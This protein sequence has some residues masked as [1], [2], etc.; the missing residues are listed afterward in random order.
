MPQVGEGTD[1]E[2]SRRIGALDELR[3][4]LADER[5]LPKRERDSDIIQGLRN[6]IRA[7][8]RLQEAEGAADTAEAATR[9]FADLSPSE[10]AQITKG[11]NQ[12]NPYKQKKRERDLKDRLVAAANKE[13]RKVI[14]DEVKAKR[15]KK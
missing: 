1:V 15:P 2:R 10:K 13:E 4:A 7:A 8:E 12:I 5:A 6:D 14:I 11:L 9:T 3:E